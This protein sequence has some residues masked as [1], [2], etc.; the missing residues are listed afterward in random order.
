MRNLGRKKILL[1]VTLSPGQTETHTWDGEDM[2]SGRTK[3]KGQEIN[4]RIQKIHQFFNM[5]FFPAFEKS[6]VKV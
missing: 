5:V 1:S 2:Q 3:F 6:Q 4:L